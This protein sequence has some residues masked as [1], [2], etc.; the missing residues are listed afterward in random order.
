MK[1]YKS[2]NIYVLVSLLNC[3]SK[4]VTEE[5]VIKTNKNVI[6]DLLRP[7]FDHGK[8]DISSQRF[9]VKVKNYFFYNTIHINTLFKNKIQIL[10]LCSKLKILKKIPEKETGRSTDPPIQ[11]TAV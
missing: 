6:A 7:D 11:M 9:R 8:G 10:L 2:Y 4:S 5:Y 1:L 3:A